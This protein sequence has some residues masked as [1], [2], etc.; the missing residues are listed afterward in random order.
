MRQVVGR[1]LVVD[2]MLDPTL[3]NLLGSLRLSNNAR[4][5]I[6]PRAPQRGL[7]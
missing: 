6:R 1:V 2:Q 7:L 5:Q 3:L 4:Y